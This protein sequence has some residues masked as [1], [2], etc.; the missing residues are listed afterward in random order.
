MKKLNTK[1]SLVLLGSI[2]VS[3]ILTGTLVI[4]SQTAI[5]TR[6]LDEDGRSLAKTIANMSVERALTDDY[7]FIQG[8]I[9]VTALGN[10]Q[11]VYIR[12]YDERPRL[13][14]VYP[15][16]A[17]EPILLEDLRVFQSPI[18][19]ALGDLPV[20]DRGRVEVGLNS[21]RYSEL[22]STSVKRMVAGTLLTFTVL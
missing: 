13:R 15:A 19:I 8:Q 5:L 11:I 17:K 12:V 1:L 7:S 2:I 10:S 21:K 4:G 6:Q 16:S 22:I 20:E 18:L 9:E 3:S 14:C